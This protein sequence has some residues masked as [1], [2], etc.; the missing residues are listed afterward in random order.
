MFAILPHI[1]SSN[2]G[3]VN[4]YLSDIYQVV[5]SFE[6]AINPCYINE[7]LQ[8][9]FKDYVQSE[10]HRLRHNLQ[11]VRYN[12][13]AMDTLALVTGPGRIGKVSAQ[14]DSYVNFGLFETSLYR[15]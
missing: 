4:K 5:T 8:S 14:L 2:R 6:A 1:L 7:T 9:K 10:E 11:T 13:D 12:I 15:S 3:P